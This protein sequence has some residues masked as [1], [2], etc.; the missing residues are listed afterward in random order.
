M[1]E[2]AR[3]RVSERMKEKV[4]NEWERNWR[5]ERE[6]GCENEKRERARV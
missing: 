2:E 5:V 4:G 6:N 1:G 3:E